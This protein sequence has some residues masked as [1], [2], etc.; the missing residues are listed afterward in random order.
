MYLIGP[1]GAFV[2]YYGQ[3]YEVE[4]IVNSILFH[5]NKEKN[6]NKSSWL[7]SLTSQPAAAP[8]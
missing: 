8:A 2:D 1:D 7:S 3:T 4:Q 5:M 6:V